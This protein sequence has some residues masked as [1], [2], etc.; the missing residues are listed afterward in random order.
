MRTTPK[1]KVHCK[2]IQ[3]ADNYRLSLL[4][5]LQFIIACMVYSTKL[6][7]GWFVLH[8]NFL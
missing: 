8:G 3:V 4:V 6:K 5:N 2:S 7:D 1:K